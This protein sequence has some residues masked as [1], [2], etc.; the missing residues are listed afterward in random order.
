MNCQPVRDLE[1]AR[2]EWTAL[3]ERS[4]NVFSTWEWASCWLR[5][6]GAGEEL[7]AQ[8]CR[9]PDGQAAAILPLCRSRK[10]PLRV[11][12]LVGHGESDE[13]G[14]ICAPADRPAANAQLAELLAGD[15]CDAFV[16][17]DMAER[18]PGASVLWRMASP[19]VR[20]EGG[21]WDEFLARRS[22]NFRQQVGK[23]ERRLARA[24]RL[25]FRVADDPA[26]L[27]A[28]IGTLFAL[29]RRHWGDRSRSFAGGREALH[30]EFAALALERGWLRLRRLELDGRAIAALYSFRFGGN[31]W[32]YQVGRD[33]AFDRFAAGFVLMS[34]SIRRALEDGQR[35]FRLLRGGEAYK[36]RFATHDDGVVTAGIARTAAGRALLQGERT[37]RALPRSVRR[38]LRRPR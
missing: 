23:R 10:G 18:P 26:R 6:K 11:L 7:R 17:H 16:G 13:L 9:R 36:Y 35:E 33:P 25:E 2:P 1:A 38:R 31:E 15:G 12:R 20:L 19:S 34:Y 24:G 4:G 27:D 8:L 14:P 37:W 32:C 21:S 22:R 28:D 30:R 3:A 5:Q 29:H